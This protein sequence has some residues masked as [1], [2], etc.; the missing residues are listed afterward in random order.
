ME[1]DYERINSILKTNR[2]LY[3]WLGYKYVI[4]TQFEHNE[5]ITDVPF[6]TFEGAAEY[7]KKE[8][9]DPNYGILWESKIF[10]V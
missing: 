10:V 4:I 2:T 6:K 9:K 1:F 3:K 8:M 5:H 7:L